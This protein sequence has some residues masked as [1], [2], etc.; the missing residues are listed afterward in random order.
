MLL[1]GDIVPNE[2]GR[3]HDVTVDIGFHGADLK[4]LDRLG[5]T[6]APRQDQ[7][8]SF[9]PWFHGFLYEYRHK[10]TARN[11]PAEP[12]WS[13]LIFDSTTGSGPLQVLSLLSDK[14]KA[15]YTD[16]L[17]SLEAT[18]RR[19]TMRHETQL[20]YPELR[21]PTPAIVWLREHGR[22]QCG[23]EFVPLADA[24]GPRPANPAAL[25]AL[26]SHPMADR[27]QEAFDLE[28]PAVEPVD[29]EDPVP[30]T[31]VWPGL[32]L[33]LT[34]HSPTFSLVRC[35]RLAAGN[36]TSG[37]ECAR[38]DA[39]IYLVGTGDEERDL[40]LVA[41]E[42]GLDLDD[43][44]LEA[45][46]RYVPP[47]E[48]EKERAAIRELTTDAER[49]LRAVGEANLRSCLPA[50][51]LAVLESGRAPLT[52]VELAE[53][54]IATHD[55]STLKEYKWALGHLAPPKR[56][57]G[58]P[59][60]VTFVQSLGFSAEWA[61]QRSS[62]R[63]PFLDVE[64]PHS[65]PPLHDYQ[66][67]IVARVR[68]ML[69]NG[70]ESNGS[71]RGMIGLPTG[72]GKT[73]IAV[74]AVV[75]AIC[76]GFTGGVLWVAD[77][78]EL[79]EQAVEAWRQVWSSVGAEGKRLRVSR[80]WAGQPPPLPASDLHVVVATIQTLNFRLSNQ[81]DKYRFLADFNLVVFDEAHRSVARTYTSV[82]GEIGLTRWQRKEEPFLLGL[83]ATPYRGH[84]EEETERLVHRYSGNRLDH[85]AF[86]SDE[87]SEVVR[88]LQEER[89]L[90]HADHETIEGGDFSLDPDELREMQA[91][92]HPA[93]LPHSMESRIA[94]D[95]ERT[96]RIVSAC[97]T[98]VDSSHRQE[99]PTLIFAT[100]VEHART[101][102]ALLNSKGVRSRA[103]SGETETSVRRNIVERFRAG[104]LDVL[105]NYGVFR[106]GFDA[107]RTRVIIVARP[108]Y[109]PNLYFQM[110][111][112]GMRGPKNG[113]NDRCL[114]I[115]VRDN[116]DNFHKALAFSELDW[117]WDE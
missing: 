6:A 49:L 95:A 83:T 115:N 17:L 56:W 44:D 113:G 1:P 34:T 58:S 53:A 97:E 33:Y 9:E 18:Y 116:I 50:S 67:C 110:I 62:R 11:L 92:P 23:G 35:Q 64:G 89:V 77:R 3:D 37:V 102:A 114:I 73:R 2:G 93:W 57:A 22:V 80:M 103:V 39:N 111:G 13:K 54:A 51:L 36:D 27:I 45:I 106:E 28:E 69:F 81:P 40:R 90:A 84:D 108:V 78:D 21:C 72:S 55:T 10:F 4:L 26:L 88:E 71:R 82:M 48:V 76:H 65:L 101:V 15:R 7:E 86:A 29:E 41:R 8:L 91:M 87:P 5:A 99:W 96:R 63:P 52:G 42:L 60:A 94:R 107:P 61:E 24:L 117:L 75:E 74:Q 85:G 109:S 43:N 38:V 46:R 25:Q 31:D 20:I 47:Q 32:T 70:H 59:L 104:E 19:W 30:L 98:F 14:G 105:V 112:R 68:E 79:C 66:K 16:A 100:S 12:R